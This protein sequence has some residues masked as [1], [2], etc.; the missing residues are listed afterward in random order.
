MKVPELR[1][2][3]QKRGLSISVYK[4]ALVWRLDEYDPSAATAEAEASAAAAQAKVAEA[5]AVVKRPARGKDL[6]HV[7]E[8]ESGVQ[9]IHQPI[10]L[11]RRIERQI[12]D[13]DLEAALDDDESPL[14]WWKLNESRFSHLS[15]LAWHLFSIAGSTAELGRTCSPSSGVPKAK[16]PRIR[17]DTAREIMCCHEN[18][19]E[20]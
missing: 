16:R 9:P 17:G 1:E 2:E 13:Y 4:P 20:R 6:W 19:S 12:R 10:S 18:I 14:Q 7:A 8:E 11:R 5:A 3:C 15:L